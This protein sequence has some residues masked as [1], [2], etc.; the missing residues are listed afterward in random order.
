MPDSGFALP[1]PVFVTPLE[2]AH[3]LGLSRSRV[4]DLLDEGVLVSRRHGTR[5]LVLLAS[6]QAFAY[7]LPA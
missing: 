2:A 4:Y 1:D 3:L 7:K 6:V 5:R